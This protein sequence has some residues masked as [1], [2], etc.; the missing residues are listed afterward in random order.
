ML[1]VLFGKKNHKNDFILPPQ[2][3]NV[4]EA[5]EQI[6]RKGNSVIVF[7]QKKGRKSNNNIPMIT[8]R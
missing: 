8:H 6:N 1:L 2:F 3:N 4:I 5:F 7:P